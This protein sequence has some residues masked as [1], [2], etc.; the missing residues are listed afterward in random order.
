MEGVDLL[1]EKCLDKKEL[2]SLDKTYALKILNKVILENKKTYESLK[3]KKFNQKSKEFDI[4]IKL[5]RKKFRD[6]FGSYNSA[7]TDGKKEILGE[8]IVTKHLSTRERFDFIDDFA[9][10]VGKTSS[11][12]DL[13]CGYNPY[14]YKHF[15]GKPKYLASDISSDL[16]HIQSFFD[17]ENIEGNTLVLDLVNESD[18]DKLEKISTEYET[19]FMLKLLDPLEKQKKNISRKIFE[20]IKSKTI[21]VSFSTMSIGG[22]VPIT[23]KRTWFYKI[24]KNKKFEEIELGPE[25]YIKINN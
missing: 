10:F 18:L 6:Y 9:L 15:L 4:I 24:I 16:K 21:I 7:L 11:I 20:K 2:K 1:L 8:E 12:L 3:Q 14:F 17:S 23:S 5:T 19:V 25:K 13:G 22:K